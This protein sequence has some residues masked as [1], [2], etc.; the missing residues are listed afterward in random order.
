M[1]DFLIG[2]KL[3]FSNE[4]YTVKE[5]DMSVQLSLSLSTEIKYYSAS[6]LLKCEDI[7]ATSKLYSFVYSYIFL[8]TSF[9]C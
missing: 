8:T 4:N 5:S 3:N 2:I 1:Y 9:L 7:N 6:V